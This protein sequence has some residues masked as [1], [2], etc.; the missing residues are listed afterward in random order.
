[1]SAHPAVLTWPGG[2]GEAT[3]LALWDAAA[4]AAATGGRTDANGFPFMW[5]A[6]AREE[7]RRDP[8]VL[9]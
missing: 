5:E 7:I 1:M 8:S 4:V 6:M 9:E 2:D 3:P